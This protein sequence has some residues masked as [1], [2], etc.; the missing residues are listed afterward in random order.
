MP[1]SHTNKH[2]L[3]NLIALCPNCHR[4]ADRGD[5]DRPSLRQYKK[6][7]QQL[8]RPRPP[9]PT[10]TFIRFT[11]TRAIDILD[12]SN[13]DSFTDHGVLDFAFTFTRPLKSAG[14]L[15]QALGSGTIHFSV[16]EQTPSHA[17]VRFAEPC[18]DVVH[19][20]FVE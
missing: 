10:R 6:I 17:R 1:W 19:L 20:E 5:I 11:P 4:R 7:C 16:V 3:E 13:I 14:F 8:T 2:D 15:I 9:E 12:S 18:P